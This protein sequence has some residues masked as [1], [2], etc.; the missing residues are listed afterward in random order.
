MLISYN[1]TKIAK[2]VGMLTN[3]MIVWLLIKKFLTLFIFIL[4]YVNKFYIHTVMRYG[5]YTRLKSGSYTRLNISLFLVHN[6]RERREGL[7]Y[8]E[9]PKLI[10]VLL[11]YTSNHLNKYTV[12]Q[13]WAKLC[14]RQGPE[15]L[16]DWWTLADSPG[17]P[18]PKDTWWTINWW[19]SSNFHNLVGLVSSMQPSGCWSYGQC[20]Q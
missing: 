5:S 18:P 12:S 15:H 6:I 2:T 10:C 17:S 3:F 14:S 20:D 19:T 9:D 8:F 11:R 7:G 4:N 16:D 13:W 1:W